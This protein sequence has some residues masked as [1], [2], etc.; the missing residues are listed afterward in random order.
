M[1]SRLCVHVR[2]PYTSKRARVRFCVYAFVCTTKCMCPCKCALNCAQCHLFP[3]PM[4]EELVLRPVLSNLE[5]NLLAAQAHGPDEV[6]EKDEHC[7][8]SHLQ[9]YRHL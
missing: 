2:E 7:H 8:N 9:T 3:L 4:F 1:C 6:L 5:F